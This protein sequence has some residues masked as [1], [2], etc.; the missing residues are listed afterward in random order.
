VQDP[1]ERSVRPIFESAFREFGLPEAIRSDNGPPFAPTGAGGLTKLSVWWM[2]L[3]IS[4]ERIDPGKPQQNGRHERMHLTLKQ[5]A[6][7]PPA[8]DF[9]AQQRVFDRFRKLYNEERPHEALEQR[10]PSS[11]YELSARTCPEKLPERG[12]RL[13]SAHVTQRT[14]HPAQCDR[15][16]HSPLPQP[17]KS[18][19]TRP[20]GRSSGVR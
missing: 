6:A 9:M 2:R 20:D 16:P 5:E 3:G 4:H 12:R 19:G 15:C 13:A 8:A 1:D 11:C 14:T 10:P 17:Q 18:D 7:S